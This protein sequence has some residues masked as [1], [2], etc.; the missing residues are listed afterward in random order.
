ML[1]RL[2]K[3]RARVNPQSVL[4]V[5]IPV[6]LLCIVSRCFSIS[7]SSPE[8]E[9]TLWVPVSERKS[10]D[11]S[12]FLTTLEGEKVA[13]EGLRNKALLLNVWA[14]WCGPCRIEMPFLAELHENLSDE[15][16]TILAISSEDAEAVKTY[17]DET[18]VKHPFP[19]LLDT[20]DILPGRFG[21]YGLP[22]TIVIDPEGRLALRHVG[23]YSWNSPKFAR[24]LRQLM[25][26]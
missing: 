24:S 1:K 20:D 19:F 13:L 15:G 14:T 23:I 8:T 21:V 5:G 3:V 12:G 11:L 6:L 18:E 16:L 9:G 25:G 7:S 10:V 26:K 2:G 17:L 4:V 22:T